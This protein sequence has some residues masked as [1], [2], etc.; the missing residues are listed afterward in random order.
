[1]AMSKKERAEVD[2][3]IDTLRIQ[4][5]LR[6]SSPVEP[7][8]A[9]PTNG[10]L[11]NGYLPIGMLSDYPAVSDACTSSISHGLTHGKTST[12]R[13]KHLY[14]TRMLALLALRHMVEKECA[15][16]LARVDLAI[17]QCRAFTKQEA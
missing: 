14:S 10:G 2:A 1:M 4:S 5:A 16:R 3:L 9:P 12:Q 13:P 8:I 6:W 7:D 11:V 17:E 15:N